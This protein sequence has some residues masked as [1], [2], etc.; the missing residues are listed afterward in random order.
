MYFP[1]IFP[2]GTMDEFK[3]HLIQFTSVF[4]IMWN[5]LGG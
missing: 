3:D 1:L 2:K 5:I 4:P